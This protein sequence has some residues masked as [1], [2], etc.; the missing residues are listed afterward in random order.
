MLLHRPR[1][2]KPAPTW[3]TCDCV[4]LL[5]NCCNEHAF[6]TPLSATKRSRLN[7][8][9]KCG[10]LCCREEKQLC[11]FVCDANLLCGLA[12][13]DHTFLFSANSPLPDS[14]QCFQ[15]LGTT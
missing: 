8:K 3:S 4:V 6:N 10:Q 1:V 5:G 15:A 13:S 7:L 14:H 2:G 12:C 11:C 9:Q